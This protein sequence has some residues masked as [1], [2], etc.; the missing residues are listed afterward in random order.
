MVQE[1][2]P[3]RATIGGSPRRGGPEPDSASRPGNLTPRRSATPQV[4]PVPRGSPEPEAPELPKKG[5]LRRRHRGRAAAVLRAN[6]APGWEFAL[7]A[8][9]VSRGEADARGRR[10]RRHPAV[11]VGPSPP[12]R[13]QP[14]GAARAADGGKR[15]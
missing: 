10:R 12:E 9:V 2:A 13:E 8:G 1:P 3:N 6:A 11:A 15:T 14:G 4:C 7:V 5:R